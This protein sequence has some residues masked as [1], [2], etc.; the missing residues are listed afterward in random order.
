VSFRLN[1]KA[2]KSGD[3]NEVDRN[4][5]MSGF[6]GNMPDADAG[7]SQDKATQAMN[8]LNEQVMTYVDF[9]I[10]WSVNVDYKF[11]YTKPK[12][13][14]KITQTLG[15]SGD[16]SLT[17]NWKISFRANFDIAEKELSNGS[18][19]IHRDLHCWEMTFNWIPVGYMQSYN[20]MINVKGSTLRD[21]L[22][23]NKRKRWQDNL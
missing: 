18:I 21:F 10:P 22:K 11:L 5:R 13:E 2:G 16:F 3:D 9:D 6:A 12:F 7:Y 23:Y 20:F 15:L 17:K 1:S 8:D 4:S 14:S 19:N